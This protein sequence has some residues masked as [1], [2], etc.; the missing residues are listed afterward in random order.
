ME[1][2]ER[3]RKEL[4]RTYSEMRQEFEEIVKRLKI[5][6]VGALVDAEF[7]RFNARL[8]ELT[9]NQR[10]VIMGLVINQWLAKLAVRG[11]SYREIREIRNVIT[12]NWTTVLAQ[13]IEVSPTDILD[14]ATRTWQESE[15]RLAGMRKEVEERRIRRR[16]VLVGALRLVT[17][18]GFIAYDAVELTHSVNPIVV[19]YTSFWGGALL[20]FQGLESIV[21]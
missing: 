3:S 5:S 12:Q 9:P 14:G 8:R 16:Q 21:R 11:Y 7:Q 15:K 6:G 1:P 13:G 20:V 19:L 10:T 17:G 18:G 4:A 2:R